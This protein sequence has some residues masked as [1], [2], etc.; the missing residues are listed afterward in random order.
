ML[1]KICRVCSNTAQ[2]QRPTQKEWENPKSY[3]GIYG[4]GFEEWIN[5][6][7]WVL[8]GYGSL[9]GEWRYAHLQGMYTK[10]N[11]YIG[12]AAEILLYVKYNNMPAIAVGAIKKAFVIDEQ[13]ATW[14]AHEMISRGWLS[15]MHQEVK[16]ISGNTDGLPPL[17]W[18]KPTEVWKS[19]YFANIRFKQE[20]LE[21][22]DIRE[23]IDIK[24]FYYDVALNW[25]EKI[26]VAKQN[27]SGK[28]VEDVDSISE[29]IRHTREITGKSYAPRQAP[30][31]KQLVIQLSNYLRHSGAKVT[32]EDNRVDV[33]IY[34]PDNTIT[35]IEIKPADTAL[36]SIRL[37]LGQLLE[38]SHYPSDKRADRLVIVGEREC[39]H[40]DIQYI[41]YLNKTYGF[42][43]RYL[44][45]TGDIPITKEQIRLLTENN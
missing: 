24:A 35:F 9:T 27:I 29:S 4:F 44:C 22:F 10:K 41:D 31:Q 11:K 39:N 3:P 15:T 45:W 2:W 1:R 37:A 14:V 25:D 13:E 21:I 6:S 19:I 30:I 32:F 43:L 18:K 17:S 26:K 8:S 38:Y 36:Q 34:C 5:R 16:A 28:T 12:E 7:E 20:D 40:E 33:K 23:N 42:S